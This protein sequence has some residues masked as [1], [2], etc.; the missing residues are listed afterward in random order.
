MD[1]LSLAKIERF[2]DQVNQS[3]RFTLDP[4]PLLALEKLKYIVNGRPT[5]AALLL[6]ADDPLRYIGL[7]F[8]DR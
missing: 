4:S 1:A 2:I 5:W 3:G 8:L 6:F 7:G